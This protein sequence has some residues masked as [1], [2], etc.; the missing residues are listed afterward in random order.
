MT[1]NK[2]LFYRQNQL[3]I[4]TSFEIKFSAD[5]VWQLIAGFNS[6]P[7]YHPSIDKSELLEQGCVR[8]IRFAKEAGGG[9]VVER[10]VFFNNETFEFSYKIIN[11][12]DCDF[13]LRNYQAYV[14]VEG[15]DD[16]NCRLHWGSAFNL[17][18]IGDEEGDRIAK[19]IYQGCFDGIIKALSVS[20]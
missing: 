15:V 13:P 18:G 9:Y 1:V 8:K 16:S 5:R 4:D 20:N 17:N 10:L 7:D 14:W 11:L 2:P 3:R 12:I 6:L 19:S